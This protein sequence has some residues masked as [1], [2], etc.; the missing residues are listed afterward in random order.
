MSGSKSYKDKFDKYA[1]APA[2]FD[3]LFAFEG[4]KLTVKKRLRKRP[5][6]RGTA[7]SL[8]AAAAVM[9]AAGAALAAVGS[10]GIQSPA[11]L[12]DGADMTQGGV[13]VAETVGGNSMQSYELALASEE[14]AAFAVTDIS[15]PRDLFDY[16]I[17]GGIGSLD[18]GSVYT[19][20]NILD[21][22]N[23]IIR[24]GVTGKTFDGSANVIVYELAP[25][26][27]YSRAEITPII[28]SEAFLYANFPVT[29]DFDPAD[30]L[31]I[32]SE[33]YIPV[34]YDPGGIGGGESLTVTGFGKCIRREGS[35][36]EM[37]SSAYEGLIKRAYDFTEDI[38]VIGNAEGNNSQV[39][40]PDSS[41]EKAFLL[42]MAETDYSYISQ[43]SQTQQG[44]STVNLSDIFR[45]D[46]P[47]GGFE[48]VN[49]YISDDGS[50][51]RTV[52]VLPNE[53]YFSLAPEMEGTV[54][55]C[56]R[57]ISGG[58]ML[59]IAPS[60]SLAALG[61]R[62]V[63]FSGLTEI[64][65]TEGDSVYGQQLGMCDSSPLYCRIISTAGKPMEID[66]LSDWQITIE[67]TV[68]TEQ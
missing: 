29:S 52:L 10:G 58:F 26:E 38:I 44:A 35:R 17:A 67:E 50:T 9:I 39:T 23:M 59:R 54:E 40:V 11:E 49:Y 4:E 57:S 18:S 25:Y 41:F 60:D 5:A 43:S 27:L 13:T 7:F 55:Y 62:S 37:D 6:H 65:C 21:V 53:S 28:S 12:S 1:G 46:D 42:Y 66:I 31:Q 14:T 64:T 30:E 15:L 68:L 32:G 45:A 61:V 48:N 36:F 2:D 20:E 34:I 8:A 16:N 19:E 51:D 63:I 33:Y 3:S 24:A 56:G 47:S 22:S